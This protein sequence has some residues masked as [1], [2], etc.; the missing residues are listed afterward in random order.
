[1]SSSLLA[2]ENLQAGYGPIN[3]LHELSLTVNAGIAGPIEAVP[4]GKSVPNGPSRPVGVGIRPAAEDD[5]PVV[6][7]R[8]GNKRNRQEV[9]AVIASGTKSALHWALVSLF[10][11][12]H[13][14]QRLPFL[15]P[16]R[17]PA[18]CP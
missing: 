17:P 13:G 12:P 15:A 6:N 3:V 14:P 5:F 8:A 1:M 2:V 4:S 10:P 18:A 11:S 16:R 7:I 9:A